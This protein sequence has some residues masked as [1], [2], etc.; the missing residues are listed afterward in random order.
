MGNDASKGTFESHIAAMATA[1]RAVEAAV[2][3]AMDDELKNWRNVALAHLQ[4]AERAGHE[5]APLLLQD[6]QRGDRDSMRNANELMRALDG[7]PPEALLASGMS[8]KENGIWE[9]AAMLFRKAA[10]LG[11]LDGVMLYANRFKDGRGVRKNLAAYRVWTLY[12]AEYGH[13][14]CQFNLGI[15]A[16]CVDYRPTEQRPGSNLL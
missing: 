8:S 5:M 13:S 4:E 6:V 2:A 3:A 10:A 16:S 9:V 7:Q 14:G 11:H 12:G 15:D 1:D